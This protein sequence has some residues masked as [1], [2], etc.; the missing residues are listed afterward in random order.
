MNKSTQEYEDKLTE[1]MLKKL[2]VQS[3]ARKMIKNILNK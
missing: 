3:K 2:K 1:K